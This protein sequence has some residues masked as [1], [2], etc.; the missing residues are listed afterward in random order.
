MAEEI[1]ISVSPLETRVAVVEM[2]LLQELYI[3]R[4]HTRVTVGNIYK[5]RVERVLPGMQSAFVDIGHQRAAFLHITDIVDTQFRFDDET[6]PPDFQYPPIQQVLREGQELLVQVTKEPINKKGARATTSISIASRFLVYMPR[7]NHLGISQRIEDEAERERLKGILEGIHP[8]DATDGFI[9][10]TACEGIDVKHIER[11]AYLLRSLWKS[12]SARSRA[13][14][15]PS[16][17][18]EDLPMHLRAMRDIINENTEA[19][20]V[21]NKDV[22]GAMGRFLNDFIPEK[23]ACLKLVSLAVPIFDSYNLEDQIET[24]LDKTVPLKSGGY[25][26]IDQTEAM[27]TIDVNTGGY[28][29]RKDVEETVYRTNLDAAATIP[30]QLKLRNIGGIVIIDFIDM[31]NEEHKRQV[32]RTLE[33]G[34]QN[35]RVKWN[36]SEISELGLVELTRKRT[37]QSLLKVMCA[38]CPTCEGKG[39]VK[40]AETVCLEIYREIQRKATRVMGKECMIMAAQPVIDRLLDEDAICVAE[41]SRAL[42]CDIKLQVEASYTQEQF[43]VVLPAR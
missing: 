7:N 10:R 25:L 21:D 26:V 31:V 29:G 41:L 43:D 6:R 40:T 1:I 5:G 17:A 20:L 27:T 2:G 14:S 42:E 35:D 23:A 33:K 8:E 22:F 16:M 4:S 37:Q 13:A 24:A 34:Q 30:R 19:I 18:Y 3:E 28:V 11:D 15:V 9:A 32:L 36:I 38:P 39:F 12:V